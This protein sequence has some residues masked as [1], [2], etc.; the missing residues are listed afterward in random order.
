VLNSILDIGA[1][2]TP[3]PARIRNRATGT[4]ARSSQGCGTPAHDAEFAVGE[5][6]LAVLRG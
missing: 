3:N 2:K 1:P 6:G 4:L 5:G